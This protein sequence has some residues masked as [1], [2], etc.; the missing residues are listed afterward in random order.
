MLAVVASWGHGPMWLWVVR[1]S[2]VARDP[3][4]SR[5]SC[6]VE[7]LRPAFFADFGNFP[8][9]VW[10][11]M[12]IMMIWYDFGMIPSWALMLLGTALE[13]AARPRNA[14]VLTHLL[15]G[16]SDAHVHYCS[17]S[18]S[19]HSIAG[20]SKK[21]ATEAQLN[22][23]P[24][25]RGK[26]VHTAQSL[27]A[28]SLHQWRQHETTTFCHMTVP[29]NWLSQGIHQNDLKIWPPDGTNMKQWWFWSSIMLGLTQFSDKPTWRRHWEARWY[30]PK[31]HKST[32]QKVAVCHGFLEGNKFKFVL[33]SSAV[34][35][36]L[37][38]FYRRFHRQFHRQKTLVLVEDVVEV[39]N[40]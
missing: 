28:S 29:E 26:T 27:I 4:S 3:G 14:V 38:L 13:F 35:F 32:I 34:I 5:W 33:Q 1:S 22:V 18:H 39:G 23:E 6:H 8:G 11:I 9:P 19:I 7:P 15:V 10:W 17:K 36:S 12:N 37:P 30:C 25:S 40:C 16:K 21:T 24:Q 31:L 2:Y 20:R